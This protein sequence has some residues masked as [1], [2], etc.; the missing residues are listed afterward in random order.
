MHVEVEVVVVLIKYS[1]PQFRHW[2]WDCA[3]RLCGREGLG[4]VWVDG[5]VETGG[6]APLF[7]DEALFWLWLWVGGKEEAGGFDVGLIAG[8]GCCEAERGFFRIERGRVCLGASCF[9]GHGS[10]CFVVRSVAVLL[11]EQSCRRIWQ[12]CRCEAASMALSRAASSEGAGS[13]GRLCCVLACGTGSRCVA[14]MR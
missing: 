4:G 8:E 12:S 13:S 7:D 10:R 9:G 1:E 2:D 6:V 11:C 5:K 3:F 14:V